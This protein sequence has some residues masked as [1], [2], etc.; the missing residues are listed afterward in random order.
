MLGSSGLLSLGSSAAG[1]ERA[2]QRGAQGKGVQAPEDG[3]LHFFPTE[4][5]ATCSDRIIT[6]IDQAAERSSGIS[7]AL[8]G[9]D[10]NE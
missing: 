3:Q 6:G 5:E 8:E 9:T 1:R 7:L 10:M 4:A 2:P